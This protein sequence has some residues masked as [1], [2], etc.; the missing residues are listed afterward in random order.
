MN[1]QQFT[2]EHISYLE[3]I[4]EHKVWLEY[5]LN[6][7]TVPLFYELLAVEVLRYLS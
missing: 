7:R 4:L 2:E 3:F 1:Y 6:F 5:E